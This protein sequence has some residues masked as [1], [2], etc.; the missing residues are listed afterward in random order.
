[1]K[2]VISLVGAGA[3]VLMLGLGSGLA[4]TSAS[5][6]STTVPAVTQTKPGTPADVEKAKTVPVK[7]GME[8]KTEKAPRSP[9]SER[10]G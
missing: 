2:K 5:K 3:M 6:E 10:S 9:R 7:P 8:V 1:M 4:Q